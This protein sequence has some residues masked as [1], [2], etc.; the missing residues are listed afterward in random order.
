MEVSSKTE[1]K[2]FSAAIDVFCE[3]GFAGARMQEI[4]DRAEI[5]KASLHYYFRSKDRLFKI[6]VQNLFSMLITQVTGE[7][8]DDIGIEELLRKLI[9]GYFDMFRKYR[10]QSL[11]LFSEMM[12]HEELLDEILQGVKGVSIIRQIVGRLQMEREKGNIGD[13]CPQDLIINIIAMCVYP[14]MTEPLIKRVFKMSDEEFVQLLD[15]RKE[16][17]SGFVLAAILSVKK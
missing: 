17:V 5:S 7:V 14:L 12:K 15:R 1:D 16:V 2:I 6:V 8:N 10:K 3:Y 11:F 4:A 13:I 9:S